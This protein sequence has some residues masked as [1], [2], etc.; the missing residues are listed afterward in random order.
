VTRL[1]SGLAHS[2]SEESDFYRRQLTMLR[3]IPSLRRLSRWI[4]VD[5]RT[6]VLQ[7]F[8][9]ELAES[10]SRADYGAMRP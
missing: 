8:Y 1:R 10:R 4:L 3:R 2:F 9:R 6:V 5:F 7:Q